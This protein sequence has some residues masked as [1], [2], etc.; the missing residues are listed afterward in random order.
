[1]FLFIVL[2]T[3]EFKRSGG[4]SFVAERD[5]SRMIR[6]G[7]DSDGEPIDGLDTDVEDIDRERQQS[8][9]V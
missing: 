6:G 4:E 5:E 3:Q 1:M 7:K 8:L 2:V 9:T